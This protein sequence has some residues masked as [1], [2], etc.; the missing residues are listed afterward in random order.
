MPSLAFLQIINPF[1]EK[2]LAE[3]IK[4]YYERCAEVQEIVAGYAA[5][6]QV[7]PERR[8]TCKYRAP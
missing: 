5:T 3:Q 2:E 6:V 4:L 7:V 8:D 1:V